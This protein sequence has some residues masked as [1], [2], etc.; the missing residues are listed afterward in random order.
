MDSL[1]EKARD[2]A[3]KAHGTQVYSTSFPYMTHLEGVYATLVD[4]GVTDVALLAAAYL[5]DTM[6]DTNVSYQDL[7]KEF[8]IEI[9]ELVYDVTD[10]L[11][12]NRKERHEK[13]YPK[14]AKN[15]KAIIL[16]LADRISNVSFSG[17]SSEDKLSMYRKE[18]AS[19]K[20]F[21]FNG[22]NLEMWAKLDELLK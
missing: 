12:R 11:G 8:G 5:H 19:F 3:L 9:A 14:T 6:E 10:E 18:H 15:K 2:Y 16:K 1:I 4:F 22:E 13:T 20:G 21:L 17:K 7:K